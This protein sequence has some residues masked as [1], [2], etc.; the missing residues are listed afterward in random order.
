[1]SLW[2]LAEYVKSGIRPELR[3]AERMP[4]KLRLGPGLYLLKDDSFLRLLG[5]RGQDPSDMTEESLWRTHETLNAALRSMDGSWAAWIEARNVTANTPA[6]LAA[7]LAACRNDAAYLLTGQQIAPFASGN[8]RELQQ[9]LSLQWRPPSAARARMDRMFETGGEEDAH[10]LDALAARFIHES[11]AIVDLFVP[12]VETLWPLDQVTADSFLF[13]AATLLRGRVDLDTPWDLSEQLAIV[14]HSGGTKP[15]LGDFALRGVNVHGWPRGTKAALLHGLLAMGIE[16]R[17]VVRW[18][19]YSEGEAKR[20]L[21]TIWNRASIGKKT[22]S[23]YVSEWF[24]GEKEAA[25]NPEGVSRSAEAYAARDD[26]ASGEVSFGKA[27]ISVLVWDED[28]KAADE[29]SKAVE[30]LLRQREFSAIEDKYH[31]QE[32]WLGSLP[33]HPYANVARCFVKSRNF[34]HAAPILTPWTGPDDGPALYTASTPSGGIFRLRLHHNDVAHTVIVG[35]TG[36]GKSVL[37]SALVL[38]WEALYG[39]GG[40]AIV[41]DKGRSARAATLCA[42]GDIRDVGTPALC[43]QP[44][45]DV[46][47]PKERA[48]AFVW[49]CDFLSDR[50]VSVTTELET[51]IADKLE[52]VAGSPRGERTLS[53]FRSFL[54]PG[55][56]KDALKPFCMGGDFGHIF[57][58]DTAPT[59]SARLLL[60]ELEALFAEDMRPALAPA[61]SHIFSLIER[62]LDGRPTLIVLDEVATYLENTAFEPRIGKWLREARKKGGAVVLSTQASNDLLRSNLHAIILDSCLTRIFLPNERA[63]ESQAYYEA[64]GLSPEKIAV[65]GAAIRRRQYIYDSKKGFAVF[66]LGLGDLGLAL[67]GASSV[68]DHRMIDRVLAAAGPERFLSAWLEARG[69]Q[70]AAEHIHERRASYELAAE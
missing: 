51:L 22:F 61:L 70:W 36:T 3:P 14:G 38:A 16:F 30:A 29:K 44:L 45:A 65:I 54:P 7:T 5:F 6:D 67:C 26:L 10:S 55:A 62:R 19:A 15:A 23:S 35:P 4:W 49:L 32:V 69:L 60:L 28:P 47:N 42:G 63:R 59:L 46:D 9:V 34:A 33:G 1:M 12:G 43:F 21:S 11:E 41:C 24:T 68:D 58:G 31:A 39:G 25:D 52:L 50:N 48:A 2:N 40:Q 20:K 57:D 18:I 37:V 66:E 56:A 8:R 13:F 27:T 17:L 53:L 64:I